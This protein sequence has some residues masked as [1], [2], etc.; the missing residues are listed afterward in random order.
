M[1]VHMAMPILLITSFGAKLSNLM[2]TIISGYNIM[3][4]CLNVLFHKDD[5]MSAQQSSMSLINP[6]R[7]YTRVMVVYICV[8]L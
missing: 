3:V 5:L 6:R 8:Y 4:L 7:A 2:T 1:Y